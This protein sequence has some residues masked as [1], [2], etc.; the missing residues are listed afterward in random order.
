MQT[1]GVGI[2]SQA[3]ADY[4]SRKTS[5]EDYEQILRE[6]LN[7]D[8]CHS[9]PLCTDLRLRVFYQKLCRQQWDENRAKEAALVAAKKA[10]VAKYKQ[11]KLR[12]RP[13]SN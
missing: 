3:Y 2:T 12:T 13:T 11:S 10:S 7:T 4:R 8:S 6:K 1:L 5:L 9:A